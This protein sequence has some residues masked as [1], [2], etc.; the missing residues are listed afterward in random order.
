MVR[1][2]KYTSK[3]IK[4]SFTKLKKRLDA[5]SI[6]K[7]VFNERLKALNE[8]ERDYREGQMTLAIVQQQEREEARRVTAEN[9]R[10]AL[11]V[12]QTARNKYKDSIGSVRLVQRGNPVSRFGKNNKQIVKYFYE[13]NPAVVITDVIIES[14]STYKVKAG[15]DQI[16]I[17]EVLNKLVE[18]VIEK[19]NTRHHGT[20]LI[21]FTTERNG[22][23]QGFF[24]A[25][26]SRN[27][28]DISKHMLLKSVVKENNKAVDS[29]ESIKITGVVITYISA[30]QGGCDSNTFHKKLG[31]LKILSPKSTRNNCVFACIH[32]PLGKRLYSENTRKQLGIASD[33]PIRIDQLEIISR[34]YDVS[35]HLCDIEGGEIGVYN[36]EC[37]NV[38]NL[39][40]FVQNETQQGHYVLIEGEVKQCSECGKSFIKKHTCNLRRK[41]WINR[42]SGRRN[43]IPSKI[44]RPEP[45]DC[46]N[47]IYYDLETFKP[48]DSDSIT[49][50]CASWYANGKYYCEY[51]E[52]AWTKFVD[53]LMT[54]EDKILSAYNGAGFDFHFLMSEMLARSEQLD[55][56][57][58]NNG[59]I[60]SF[61]F[62]KN[63]RCWD[64][65]LF[66]LSSLKNACRDF[67]VS[68]ENAKTEFDHFKIKSWNDVHTYR[69]EVE[70]YIK[71][72]VM[73][74]KEVFEKFSAM[75]Y[76]LFECHMTEYITL[77]AMSYSIW[78]N[79]IKHLLELPDTTKY[80]FIRSS[81]Y[82]G[83]TYPMTR[84]Y[85][86]KHYTDIMVAMDEP[87]KLKDIYKSMD[88]YIFNGDVSSL[89]PT[90][91]VKYE[92]PVG[93]SSWVDED[94]IDKDNLK[95]GIYECEIEC[96]KD[97]VVPILPEKTDNGGISWNL[98]DKKG[99]YTSADLENAVKYGYKIKR[100]TKGLVWEQKG[101]VFTEYIDKTYKLKVENDKNP[102]LRQVAKI[103]MNALYGKMLERARFEEQKVCNNIGDVWKFQNEFHTTDVQFIKDK[104]VCIGLPINEKVSDD[105]IRKPSHIGTFIL[106]YSRTHMLE[107]MEAIEPGL[108]NHF[109]TY[110][111]TD[112]LH[113]HSSKLPGLQ[114]RGWL[115]DGLGMLS[116]DA[117]GGRI[118]REINLAPKLYMYLCLMPNGDIKT[119]MKS[120]G[121]PQQYL[122]P[123]LFEEA[124]TLVD[125]D[126]VIRME[127]RLKKVGFGRNLQ[128][129]WRKYDA[130][131]ILSV[132]ME[133]TFYKNMWSGMDFADGKWNPKK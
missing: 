84:E 57:I 123:H 117:K 27:P 36:K 106:S 83:R 41:M 23:G 38:I 91:M 28:G 43:V 9:K 110:T 77:S 47:M 75:V 74:M 82:G 32:H 73:G 113:I 90:A 102:V 122:S 70:P 64:L 114:E 29:Y 126:K 52:E 107:V 87:D 44:K 104:V 51:G 78:T 80:E 132:D 108:R 50:Y 17:T 105:R 54:Q 76:E 130:F 3:V 96:N 22:G 103:L 125:E 14:G 20:A 112:S 62:G 98:M 24:S 69:S 31:D 49:P 121:I 6:N 63:I 131:S 92:Y 133:R 26:S 12:L 48:D 101:D 100:I 71:R 85:T 119:C 18:E 81:L 7:S 40:L 53:F 2:L 120:K 45:F 95:I 86:S 30:P 115:K 66:T 56:C 11:E 10:R 116:D 128:V 127:H 88:D 25:G 65:C 16:N 15:N 89:Y 124:D 61:T 21:T 46:E 68:G 5:G 34:F 97:L 118:F 39:M 4:A 59:R 99:V 8:R 94:A 111:D 1:A 13:F 79:S 67:G 42:M 93:T 129:A 60:L 19:L 55:K 58:I 33:T 72:D 37:A 109:F 35:I